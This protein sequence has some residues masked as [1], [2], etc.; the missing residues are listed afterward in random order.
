[1]AVSDETSLPFSLFHLTM[2][3]EGG[4]A[5]VDQTAELRW[6][7]GAGMV[8]ARSRNETRSVPVDPA[9]VRA[10]WDRLEALGFWE[11]QPDRPAPLGRLT[12]FFLGPAATDSIETTV[13]ATAVVDGQHRSAGFSVSSP[14]SDIDA[15]AL[16]ALWAIDRFFSG[17]E[18]AD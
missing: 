8:T 11:R 3:R 14:P 4:I 10:L 2:H 15:R 6:E 16:D 5:S 12:R 17:K 1:V 9:R 18:A 13:S 7:G